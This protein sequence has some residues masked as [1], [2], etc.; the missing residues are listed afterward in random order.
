MFGIKKQT[1]ILFCIIKKI[2]YVLGIYKNC[3]FVVTIFGL[4]TSL[5]S[6]LKP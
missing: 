5:S 6:L 3:I 4:L 1:K 2:T